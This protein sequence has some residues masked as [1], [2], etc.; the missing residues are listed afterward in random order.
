MKCQSL[1]PGKIKKNIP[2]YCLF[3]MFI[4]HA[5][6]NILLMNSMDLNQ[7]AQIGRLIWVYAACIYHMVIIYVWRGS[8]AS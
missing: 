8:Y 2:N 1:F 3:E 7:T 5:V 6:L 4:Q